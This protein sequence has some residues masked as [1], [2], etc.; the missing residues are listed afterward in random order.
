MTF[1][2]VKHEVYYLGKVKHEVYYLRYAYVSLETVL[3]K[4]FRCATKRL[5]QDGCSFV[6]FDPIQAFFELCLCL[7]IKLCMCGGWSYW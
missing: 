3:L 6:N 2:K 4:L 7:A 1:G 5:L